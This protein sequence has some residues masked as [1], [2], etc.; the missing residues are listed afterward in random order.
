MSHATK[1]SVRQAITGGASASRPQSIASLSTMG[2]E[3]KQFAGLGAGSF[4]PQRTS[5]AQTL[6]PAQRPRLF[7]FDAQGLR[8]V[9]SPEAPW[10]VAKDVCDVLEI[11][12]HRDT[13]AKMLDEDEKGV[14]TIYTLGGAQDMLTVNESGLYCLI[15][16]SRKPAARVFRKWVTAEVLPAIRRTG[17]YS[18]DSMLVPALQPAPAV[19]TRPDLATRHAAYLAELMLG[20]Q[21]IAVWRFAD[22]VPIVISNELFPWA[23]RSA[24]SKAEA[25]SFSRTLVNLRNRL[26]PLMDGFAEITPLGKA[27]HRKYVAIRHEGGRS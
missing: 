25:S 2:G 26:L 13:L 18:M 8:V 3:P 12:N 4:P 14:D 20:D 17:R 24:E 23:I 27:R 9:G 16:R 19:G 1:T 21:R 6:A 15:F 7:N 5:G 22:L 10:F 11:Q